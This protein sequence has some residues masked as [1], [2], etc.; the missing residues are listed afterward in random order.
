MH[1]GHFG[2]RGV[3]DGDG[4]TLQVVQTVHQA[5]QSL[6]A[7]LQGIVREV[8]GAAVVGREDEGYQATLQAVSTGGNAILTA[9][10]SVFSSIINNNLYVP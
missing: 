5:L 2:S 4:Y 3:V 1:G 7:S 6:L 8:Y 9:L 10:V